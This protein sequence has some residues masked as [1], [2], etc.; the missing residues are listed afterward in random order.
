MRRALDVAHLNAPPSESFLA[1]LDV[2]NLAGDVAF[3]SRLADAAAERGATPDIRLGGSLSRAVISVETGRWNDARGGLLG[4]LRSSSG[5]NPFIR[6]VAARM[7]TICAAAPA[8]NVS[9]ADV[10]AIR[11]LLAADST[12]FPARLNG[13]LAG[14]AEPLRLY[15]LGVLSARLG[16]ADSAL[17]LANRLVALQ[18]PPGL[19]TVAAGMAHGVRAHVEW[20]RGNLAAALQEVRR[21]RWLYPWTCATSSGISGSS[22]TP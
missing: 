18:L 20:N 8:L 9:A 17:A 10:G 1:A 2:L 22:A 15:T 12:L 5:R 16:E 13:R 4:V 21:R 6:H 7:A 11:Q 3:A 14:A 19:D